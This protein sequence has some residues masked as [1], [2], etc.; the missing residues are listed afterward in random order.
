MDGPIAEEGNAE[1]GCLHVL[2][3]SASLARDTLGSH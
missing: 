1:V 2:P 3:G